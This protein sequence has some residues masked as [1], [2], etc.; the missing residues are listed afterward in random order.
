M[1][2]HEMVVDF[3]QKV[4]LIEKRKL[5]LM[6]PAEFSLSL[7]YLRGEI[8]EMEEAYDLGDIVGVL[9]GLIDLNFFLLGVVY[10]MGISEESFNQAFKVV[11]EANMQKKL[12]LGRKGSEDI[13]DAVKPE[14]WVPPESRLQEILSREY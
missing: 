6:D 13:L 3:N 14:D 5:G 7:K 8:Q 12:G 11:Y 10:K 1:N 2:N 9:D 4:L